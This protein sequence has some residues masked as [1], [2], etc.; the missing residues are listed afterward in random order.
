VYSE[1]RLDSPSFQP[2]DELRFNSYFATNLIWTPLE[3]Y[4]MGIEYLYGI[5]QNVDLQDSEANRLQMSFG[6]YLP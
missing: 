3:N 1:N 4:F 5:R 2:G 6:F